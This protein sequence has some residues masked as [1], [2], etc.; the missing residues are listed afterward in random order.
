MEHYFTIPVIATIISLLGFVIAT[1]KFYD[2]QKKYYK[3]KFNQEKRLE[4]KLRIYEILLNDI[5]PIDQII[6]KFNNHSPTKTIDSIE[7][8]KCLYEMLIE[9]TIVSFENGSY[10][11]DTVSIDEEQH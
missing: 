6:L 7:I 11:T 4:Y 3:I 5:L 1:Y 10:T 8:R 9:K 2:E